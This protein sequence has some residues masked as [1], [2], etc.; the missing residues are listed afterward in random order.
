M[1]KNAVANRERILAAAEAVFG[2]HGAAGSTEDVARRAEVGIATVFR[3]FPTKADL[4]EAALVRHFDLLNERA[5]AL[6]ARADAGQAFRDLL[7]TMVEGGA[8][9]L[10]LAAQMPDGQFP[11]SV[12]QGADTLRA[13]VEDLMDRAARSGAV[14][15]DVGADEVYLLL[16]GLAQ[17]CATTPTTPRTISRAI[18]VVIAG[19][20][21]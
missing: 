17:A 13:T 16:R 7:R 2:E 15:R 3:H 6:A 19:L 11:P 8:T 1:R 4:I 18:D 21:A 5:C 12:R 14:R 20:N 10:T 9:K